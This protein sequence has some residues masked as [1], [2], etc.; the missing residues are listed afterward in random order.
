MPRPAERLEETDDPFLQGTT[1][2]ELVDPFDLDSVYV[3]LAFASHKRTQ[4]KGL[5]SIAQ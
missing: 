3:V 4:L 1:Q 5:F 2:G